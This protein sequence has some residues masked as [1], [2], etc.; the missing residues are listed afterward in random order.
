MRG[1]L[2]SSMKMIAPRTSRLNGTL[3]FWF[4]LESVY[5][6]ALYLDHIF[7]FQDACAMVYLL[8]LFS[9]HLL[10]SHSSIPV[11]CYL[12]HTEFKQTLTRCFS[13]TTL[14][15]SFISFSPYPLTSTILV[16]LHSHLVTH[17]FLYIDFVFRLH[18]PLNFLSKRV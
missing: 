14:H 17:V 3:R 12:I 2:Q 1:P 11:S 18:P 15:L 8:V 10:P 7:L 16:H 13:L 5:N 9:S 4:K 6:A